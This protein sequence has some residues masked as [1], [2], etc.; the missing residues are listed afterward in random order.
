MP[1]GDIVGQESAIGALRRSLASG[2]TAHAYLFA[3]VEGCG[4]K[5][6]ALAFIEAVFCGANEGCGTC[7]SCRKVATLQHP[8]LHLVEPDGAFIKIDQ[9]RELQRQL[10]YRPFEAPLK[11]CI[12]DEADRLNAAA[13]NALLKTL[14]EPPGHA[15]LVLLTANIGGVL[16]TILSRCQQLAFRPLPLH[17]IEAY[18][19]RQGNDAEAASLAA[20]LAAGSLSKALS[21]AGETAI[22]E[23]A[24]FLDRVTRLTLRDASSLFA[25]AEELASDKEKALTLLQLLTTFLRDVMLL[26][27]GSVEVVNSDLL[28]LL[29]RE[30]TRC[31]PQRTMDRLEAVAEAERALQRNVNPRL[32]IEVL[33]MR[34][35]AE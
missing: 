21:L 28:S 33:F 25:A 11:A 17:T 31:S 9:V 13:G 32:A 10:A 20:S 4:K 30:A 24:A 14:E 26:Q 15:L 3:G 35:A 5:K 1:F 7:P 12:I 34:L 16:P 19:M 18:L 22:D 29:Q 23:R 27:G 6:T 2:R 8:D